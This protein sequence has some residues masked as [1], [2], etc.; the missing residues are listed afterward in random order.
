VRL[1][2]ELRRNLW[3]ELTPA[4]LVV[5][6]AILGG[7]LL[8]AWLADG[9]RMGNG[10][11]GTALAC[12]VG[13]TWLWGAHL[14]AESILSELRGRTWD[15]QRMSG[16]GP[17][18]LA[19]GK[20]AGSTVYPWY[21]ALFCAIAW[22]VSDRGHALSEQGGDGGEA[23]TLAVFVLTGLLSQVVALLA[24]LQAAH[25]DRAFTRAQSTAW[26]VLAAMLIYPFVTAGVGRQHVD[27]FGLRY[28]PMVFTL[29]SLVAFVAFGLL[30]LWV[31]VR[32]ELK[33]RTLPFAWPAFALFLMAWFAGFAFT[34]GGRPALPGYPVGVALAVATVLTW[35]AA[36]GERKDPVAISRLLRA[37]REDR[38]RRAAEE[39]PAWLLTLPFVLALA[40]LVAA[41]PTLLW[42][43]PDV[44]LVR[45]VVV[46]GLGFLLRDLAL[47]LFLNLGARPRRADVFAAVLLLVG[48]VLVPLILE[49]LKWSAAMALFLPNPDHAAISAASGILQA[50]LVVALL[51]RRW[52]LRRRAVEAASAA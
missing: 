38:W 51:V 39:A 34:D 11:A 28:E 12:I 40:I 9:R 47:V 49:A 30:G 17:W 13:L 36:F 42:G 24:A 52:R 8:L 31:Q 21:G 26:L 23:Q 33:V 35:A 14:A 32:R 2:P 44:W 15:W 18:T 48:Y 3:L 19:W 46:A 50:G 10:T 5:M 4:R 16:I 20:L 29:R 1:N 41:L 45:W 43:S 7:L 27:W 22:A 37:A 25:R 6:P